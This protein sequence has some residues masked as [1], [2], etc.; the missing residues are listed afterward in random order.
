M[1]DLLTAYGAVNACS[2]DGGSS[3]CMWFNGEYLNSISGG[4][5]ARWLPDAF[6]VK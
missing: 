1:I 3:T 4:S 2:L 6:L 5:G